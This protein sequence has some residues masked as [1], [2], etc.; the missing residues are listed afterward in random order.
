LIHPWNREQV[1]VHTELENYQSIAK[2][3]I[4]ERI[5]SANVEE[6][7]CFRNSGNTCALRLLRV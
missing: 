6:R 7:M 4:L 3:N 2:Q 5:K 1:H